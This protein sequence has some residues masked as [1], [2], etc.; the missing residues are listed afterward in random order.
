MSTDTRKV[1]G[2]VL[3]LDADGCLI[4]WNG[5]DGTPYNCGETLDEFGVENLTAEELARVGGAA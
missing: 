2:E 1:D 3:G 4:L 5:S